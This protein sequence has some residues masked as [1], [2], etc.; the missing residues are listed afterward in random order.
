MFWLWLPLPILSTIIGYRSK[1]KN[2]K[3]KNNIISGYIISILLIF[4]G[5]FCIT[6]P[7]KRINYNKI[8]KYEDVF[9]VDFPR[10]GDYI[11]QKYETYFDSDKKNV[12]VTEGFFKNVT[13][14]KDLEQEI[15]KN[16]KWIPLKNISD[17]L[18]FLVPYQMLNRECNNC[19]IIIYNESNKKY[20]TF[21][22]QNKNNKVHVALYDIEK[23]QIE[24]N[25]YE[26]K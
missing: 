4:F 2:K 18:K 17:E 3:A 1:N 11:Q 25:T 16:E 14:L 10:K 8:K 7:T 23:K 26:I 21:T 24:I 13:E 6:M 9:M 20:N 12:I 5:S 22:N 15:L 19:Y